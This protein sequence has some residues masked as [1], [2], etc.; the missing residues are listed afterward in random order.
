MRLRICFTLLSASSLAERRRTPG[1]GQLFPEEVAPRC[2][3][4]VEQR[5][6]LC[7]RRCGLLR[8]ERSF[9]LCQGRVLQD[10]LHL[11]LA[12]RD[13][14]LP[15]RRI[16]VRRHSSFCSYA[17]RSISLAS[18]GRRLL[19]AFGG[20]L[21]LARGASPGG[22]ASLAVGRPML[23]HNPKSRLREVR[24]LQLGARRFVSTG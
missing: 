19:L 21:P 3:G 6:G 24:L 7:C 18:R 11:C 15:S 12:S 14:Q 9:L 22:A 13:S 2:P 8:S 5:G 10:M 16:V 4:P 17:L 20:C 1:V 23:W